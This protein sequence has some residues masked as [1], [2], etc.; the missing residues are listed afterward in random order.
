MLQAIEL[1]D[2][3]SL[4]RVDLYPN[5]KIELNMGGISLL[6]LSDRVQT[7]TNSFDV[8]R[9][10]NNE[11][12]FGHASHSTRNNRPVISVWMTVGLFQSDAIL[13]VTAF[14]T[15]YKCVLSYSNP[16]YMEAMKTTTI[17]TLCDGT[18]LES[19]VST[20]TFIYDICT[21]N[22]LGWH[23]VLSYSATSSYYIPST[24]IKSRS[25]GLLLPDFISLVE[26]QFGITISGNLLSD[27]DF[28]NAYL[29]VTDAYVG[30]SGT[31]GNY[32]FTLFTESSLIVMD[33]LKQIAL[34][35]FKDIRFSGVLLEFI[36]IEK[37][38]S[39]LVETLNFQSKEILSG[40]GKNNRINYTL[41]ETFEDKNTYGDVFFSTGLDDKELL[42]LDAYIPKDSGLGMYDT[43]GDDS[44]S[45]KI[46]LSTVEFLDYVDVIFMATTL[47]VYSDKLT[48]YSLSG[49]YS[50]YLNTI[51]ENPIIINADGWMSSITAS[52]LISERVILSKTLQG[53]YWVENMAYDLLT[54]LSK[55]KL[56]RL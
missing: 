29:N 20:E 56:I 13:T 39:V 34:L 50:T 11:Y 47:N 31:V 25:L 7:Y 1:I 51:F 24:T 52:Q 21:S 16:A 23:N 35:F 28:Q 40:L 9:T 6:S 22:L 36:D 46:V 12:L 33:V 4:R 3:A 54:G 42:K 37:T 48:F 43:R 45:G 27:A 14:D 19:G 18:V 38:G 32:T 17:G 10:P 5:V 30:R 44:V 49:K 41:S 15:S 26:T 2:K 55:L 53:R 8:P